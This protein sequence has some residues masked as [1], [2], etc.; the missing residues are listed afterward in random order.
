MDNQELAVIFERIANLLEIKGEVI[1]KTL[2]Y[3]RAAESLRN[4]GEEAR[5]LQQHGRLNE[6]PG[7]GKAIAE[8]IEELLTTGRLEFLEKLEAEVPPGLAELLQVPDVG[9]KKTAMLWKQANITSLADLE[10]AARAGKLRGL[11]GIGEKAEQRILAGIEAVARRSKRMS[12]EVAMSQAGRWLSWLRE[13]PGIVQA[14]AAGSLR[15][16]K[17]TVG[18][19]DLVAASTEPQA[20]MEA[21]AKH[22]EVRAVLGGG[23]NKTS[24]ELKNGVTMQV[25]IQPPERFG[26]LLQFVTGSKDHNVRVR[27]LAQKKGLSL[28]EHGFLKEDGSELIC[29][30]EEDVYRALGM[31]WMPP[32]LREDRGEVRAALVGK[33]PKLID[34]SDLRAE[35]HSH[36][37]WSDGAASIEEM[38]RAAVQR[39]LKVLAVTDHSSGLGVAGG[40]TPERLKEQRVELDAVQA[41]LGSQIL[42]LQGAEV[43]IHADGSLDFSDEVLASLDIVIASLHS[44]LRQPR[45]AVTARLIRAIRNPHVDIIGHPT[46]RLM[47]N[48]EGADLDMEAVLAAA[49]E[50]GTA[51]EINASPYRLDLDETYARRAVEMGISLAINTDAHRPADL[52]LARFGVSVARR[53]W[54]EAA[55]VINTWPADRLRAWLAEHKRAVPGA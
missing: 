22:P 30:T 33:L 55:A 49:L 25:W 16:W 24:V 38:A 2:A 11:P 20:A 3:R 35:L 8:K 32:E 53:A 19:L 5:T 1:Y 39:G 27:E 37:T 40:L 18:D 44:S 52:E 48:R 28:S 15:R 46:G 34:T 17:A 51:L 47:P 14:E 41:R 26:S 45:E 21:L 31:A 50:S 13:Q 10:A 7:V 6:I 29:A 9:P 23:P 43:E 42:L 12:L 36:T 4:H 54:L